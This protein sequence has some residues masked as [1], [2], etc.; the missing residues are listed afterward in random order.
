MTLAWVICRFTGHEL[1]RVAP[2]RKQ[3]RRCRRMFLIRFASPRFF[4]AS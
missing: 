2:G 1:L 4:T 3:C